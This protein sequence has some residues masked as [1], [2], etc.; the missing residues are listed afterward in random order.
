MN[1]IKRISLFFRKFFVKESEVKMIEKS[2]ETFPKQTNSDFINSIKSSD[3]K[4]ANKVET[5]I[6]DGDGIG[7]QTEIKY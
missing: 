3:P 1:I 7:I 4:K 6:C 5:L 2:I